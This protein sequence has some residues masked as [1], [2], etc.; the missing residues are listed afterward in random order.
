MCLTNELPSFFLV[1]NK[2]QFN[3]LFR[4]I[5]CLFP[6]RRNS[7]ANL[8]S[9]PHVKQSYKAIVGEQTKSFASRIKVSLWS[10]LYATTQMKI[11]CS[12]HGP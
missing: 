3:A 5:I 4:N 6:L 2:Q 8:G 12:T 11:L 9:I 7:T 10:F 1:E